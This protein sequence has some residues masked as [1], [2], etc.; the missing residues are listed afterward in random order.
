VHEGR[1]RAGRRSR[2]SDWV[3][4]LRALYSQ[5]PPDLAVLD[6]AVA[7]TLLPPGLGL[8]VR[9]AE[10]VPLGSRALHRALGALTLGLTFDVPLRSAAIDEVVRR[11]VGEGTAQLVLLGAGLDARA[12]RM[13]ELESTT[14][15]ELDHP[16]TQ[17]YKQ[18]R[19]GPLPPLARDVRFLAIDFEHQR[20]DEVLTG[21]GFR[22]DQPSM[23][24]WEGVAMYLTEEAV[25]LTLA[26]IARIASSG[27]RLAMTYVPPDFAKSWL[28]T[29]GQTA[30]RIVGE[31][32]RARLDPAELDAR[33]ERL[34][35]SVESDDTAVEWARRYWPPA[36]ARRARAWER[37]MVARRTAK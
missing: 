2:T 22:A 12:W 24:I 35:F 16:S 15:Y 27:S 21:A 1:I 6:D 3:A 5:A 4:A 32:L 17:T 19:I 33:L 25:K 31:P 36:E 11:A 28:R 7:E 37:L 20:I 10:I 23:W 30:S 14:V 26:T 8:V 18:E 29:L 9:A 13:P 34:G